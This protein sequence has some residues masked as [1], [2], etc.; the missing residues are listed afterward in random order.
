MPS[1]WYYF[2]C[3]QYKK[4]V[5]KKNEKSFYCQADV[6]YNFKLVLIFYNVPGN[7][8][9]EMQLKVYKNQILEPM[10]ES[11]LLKIWDFLLKENDNSRYGKTYNEN[12]VQEVQ[13]RKKHFKYVFIYTLFLDLSSIE[14]C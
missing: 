3:I 10:V 6:S 1:K 5:K 9:G 14:N 7:N 11:W 12:I 13:K 4:M 2:A 8:N